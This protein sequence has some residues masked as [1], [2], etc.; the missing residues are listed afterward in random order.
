MTLGLP[1]R[2]TRRH[3]LVHEGVPF[4]FLDRIASLLQVQREVIPEAICVSPTTLV[5]R[6]KTG[7]F[8]TVESDRLVALIA[9]FAQALHLFENDVAAAT[10]G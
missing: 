6:A 2:G 9:V 7:R 8:N 10:D 4:E 5:R 1:S 3:D